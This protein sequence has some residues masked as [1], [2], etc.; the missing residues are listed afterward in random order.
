[1]I[2][3]SMDVSEAKSFLA[4][5]RGEGGEQ[6]RALMASARRFVKDGI[7]SLLRAELSIVL[8]RDDGNTRN[9]FRTRKLALSGIGDLVL[10]VPRDRKSE[11]RTALLPFRKRRTAELEEPGLL[12]GVQ[13]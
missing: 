3:I 13:P 12:L 7:E 10:S 5:G 6:A 4:R 9:G 1:M 8:E 2:S 11:Y